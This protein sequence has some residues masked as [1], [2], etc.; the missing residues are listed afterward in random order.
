MKAANALLQQ[1]L[2]SNQ[3]E[4]LS[5]LPTLVTENI[6]SNIRVEGVQQLS[7]NDFQGLLTTFMEQYHSN[8]EQ[9]TGAEPVITTQISQ[10]T[11][12]DGYKFWV[13]DGKMRPVPQN[14]SFPRGQVKMICDLFITGIAV[15]NTE[16][17]IRPLRLIHCHQLQRKDQSYFTRAQ[18]VFD[19]ICELAVIKK[20]CVD[21]KSFRNMS[22][23]RWDEIFVL[24]FEYLSGKLFE[25][26][27]V[28]SKKIGSM[29]INTF[30]NNVKAYTKSSREV[31]PVL[32]NGSDCSDSDE[33]E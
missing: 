18:F 8:R 25:K 16:F 27:F 13:Y 20:L 9:N 19:R 6:L 21:V 33:D 4:L 7:K 30:Y 11:D 2:A 5:E 29:S 32:N 1:Q 10:N 31:V 14:W 3:R 24:C 26:G 12:S 22:L 15:P 17:R 28:K 23:V